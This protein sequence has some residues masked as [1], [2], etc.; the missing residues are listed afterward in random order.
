MKVAPRE[1]SKPAIETTALKAGLSTSEG[2]LSL[3]A[4]LVPLLMPV[5][6]ALFAKIG[7]PLDIDAE[8]VN[9]A[10][11]ANAGVTGAYV[12]GRSH[13]KGKAVGIEYEEV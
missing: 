12:W 1:F 3:L 13:V 8:T 10:I 5:V 7:L 2:R 11:L 6:K 9:T 4:I